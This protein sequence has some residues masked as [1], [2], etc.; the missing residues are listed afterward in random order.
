MRISIVI[1]SYN[2]GKWVE[3]TIKSIIYQDYIDKEIL[4]IDGGSTDESVE[5]FKKYEQ[6]ITYWV[7]EKD[8]GQAEAIN[9][10]MKIAKGDILYYINSDDILCENALSKVANFFN[11]HKEYDIIAG[12][13]IIIDQDGRQ[14]GKLFSITD[15]FIEM[16]IMGSSLTQP[17]VFFTRK[18]YELTGPFDESLFFSLD[19]EY[20]IRCLHKGFKLKIIDEFLSGVRIHKDTKSSKYK[21]IKNKEDLLIKSKYPDIISKYEYRR[22]YWRL[23]RGLLRRVKKIFI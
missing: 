13:S 19:Y 7:S 10:G 8:N 9:K 11:K 21:E 15:N 6:Y 2:Q 1:P 5:I 18:C 20:W 14:L 16:L 3:S 17:S 12:H 4:I 22:F 23:K